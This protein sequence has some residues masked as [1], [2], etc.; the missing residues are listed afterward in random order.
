ME[1]EETHVPKNQ[2]PIRAS[3]SAYEGRFIE[4]GGFIIAFEKWLEE[5]DETNMFKDLPDGRCSCPHW[6]FLFKGKMIV[7]YK[8]HEETIIAGEAYYLKP[9][10]VS[11]ITK[12]TESMEVSPKREYEEAMAVIIKK[13]LPSFNR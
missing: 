2:I 3:S 11:L 4:W 5:L 13:H 7:R 8:E 1:R 6:G 12:G 9:G 10:H